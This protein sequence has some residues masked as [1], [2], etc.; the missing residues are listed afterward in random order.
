M[1]YLF[2]VASAGRGVCGTTSASATLAI[3]CGVHRV[4]DWLVHLHSVFMA[5]LLH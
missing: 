5:N 3:H 4:G 2:Q 1:V